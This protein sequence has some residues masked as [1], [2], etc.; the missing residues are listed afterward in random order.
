MGM[1][2]LQPGGPQGVRFQIGNLYWHSRVPI[3]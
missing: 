1:R 2:S 3:G